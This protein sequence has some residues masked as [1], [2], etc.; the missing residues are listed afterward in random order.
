[1]KNL[2][3]LTWLNNE[4]KE[5]LETSSRNYKRFA[6]IYFQILSFSE[7]ELIV[8]VWQMK[9]SAQKYLSAKEL[10]ERTKNVFDSKILPE[11]VSLHV[12]PVPYQQDE[13][14]NFSTL[15]I[16]QKMREFGLRPKD[17]GRLLDI[18]KSSLSSM[19]SQRRELS[20]SGKA[21]FYYF[22]KSLESRKNNRITHF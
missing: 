7:D 17:L 13:L 16:E 20:K 2:E 19:L 14:R 22:F 18:D 12:R 4:Q 21:M 15:N 3:L 6:R 10:V 9:N 5:M 8:K 1:M 11:N